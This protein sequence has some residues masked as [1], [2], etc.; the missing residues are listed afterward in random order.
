MLC[1]SVASG[2]PLCLF[3]SWRPWRLLGA[4]GGES[5]PYAYR[6]EAVWGVRPV[7][8]SISA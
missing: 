4:F 2:L 1:V 6:M 5:F 3:S 8:S 7:I